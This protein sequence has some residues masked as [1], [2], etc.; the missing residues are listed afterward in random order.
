MTVADTAEAM[1]VTPRTI[2]HLKKRFVEERLAICANVNETPC[3]EKISVSQGGRGTPGER[4]RCFRDPG[5]CGGV[6]R[7]NSLRNVI[8]GHPGYLLPG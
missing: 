6:F 7:R 3:P 2:E 4:N 5:T 8:A 1:G